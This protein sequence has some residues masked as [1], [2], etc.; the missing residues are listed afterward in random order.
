MEVVKLKEERISI[1]LNADQKSLIDEAAEALGVSVSSFVLS[2]VLDAA[3]RIV[4]QKHKIELGERAWMEFI[5][6]ISGDLEPTPAAT[7][8]AERYR[9]K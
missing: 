1:R 4:D 9:G 2:N 3:N 5:N 7:N 8:A 6:L